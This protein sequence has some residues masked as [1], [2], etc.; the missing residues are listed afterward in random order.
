MTLDEG[1]VVVFVGFFF[2]FS[3]ASLLQLLIRIQ[4]LQQVVLLI[5]LKQLA[6][7]EFEYSKTGIYNSDDPL[8]LLLLRPAE[9]SQTR[10]ETHNKADTNT[11][12]HVHSIH[13][14]EQE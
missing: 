13:S 3:V 12:T 11:H 5:P 1:A 7:F 10:R 4:G 6:G 8:L 9:S 2:F 14:H